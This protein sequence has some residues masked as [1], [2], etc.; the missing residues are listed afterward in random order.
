MIHGT[1]GFSSSSGRTVV[2]LE[3]W[4]QMDMVDIFAAEYH[5]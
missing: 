4:K 2:M 3:K 1:L 5:I